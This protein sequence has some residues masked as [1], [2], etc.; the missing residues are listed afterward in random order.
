MSVP[1]VD[2][3]IDAYARVGSANRRSLEALAAVLTA[4]ERRGIG[5]V[6]LKGADVLP[7]LYGVWGLRPMTDVDLLVGGR[8]LPAIDEALRALGYEPEIAGNPTYRAPGGA[9]ILD[10]L[11]D[12]WYTD[13]TDAVWRR[14]V[15]QDRDGPGTLGMA[16][17]DL[18]IFLTAYAVLHR[19]Y[20][21]P[22]FSQDLGLLTRKE[23][24]DW[25]FVLAE[26]DR[27]R[28]RIPLFHGLSY[29]AGRA[30]AAVPADV[31]ARLAPAHTG[32]RL[33]AFVLRRLV[34]EQPIPNLGHFLLLIP[35]PGAR[36][37]RRLRDA[38]RPSREF[39]QYR[40]GPR[41]LTHPVWTRISR[42]QYLA[43][44]ALRLA[45]RIL[46]RLVAPGPADGA[47]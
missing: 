28:L 32:E 6:L 46:R 15:R 12:L 25:E 20:F 27:L 45:G 24:L 30:A 22:S 34:R 13:D 5:C 11:T 43:V 14:A 44:Q 4:L 31:L 9:L 36:G 1:A 23:R 8:D 41:G 21:A 33:L 37:W 35:G 38:V 19:G 7:R 3:W 17:E 47:A 16:A 40:Y 42:A 10:L 29:V 18:I 26:A 2:R 39:L